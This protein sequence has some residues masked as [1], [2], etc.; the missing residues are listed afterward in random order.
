VTRQLNKNETV[1][2]KKSGRNPTLPSAIIR[3]TSEFEMGSGGS[4][5]LWSPENWLYHA[6]M[7][8]HD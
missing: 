2:T 6:A 4:K 1:N 8:Q 5:F 3:F 7:Q